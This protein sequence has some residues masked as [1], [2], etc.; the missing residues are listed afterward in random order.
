MAV[1][2]ALAYY[3]LVIV[4]APGA[5]PIKMFTTVIYRFP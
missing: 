4:L 1:A 5:N 3:D 2:K